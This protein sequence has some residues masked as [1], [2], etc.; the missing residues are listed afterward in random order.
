MIH[1]AEILT[2]QN[3]FRNEW[4][5]FRI[6]GK[7]WVIKWNQYEKKKKSKNKIF[8]LSFF[9][10]FFLVRS[11]SLSPSLSP[12]LCILSELMGNSV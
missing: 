5:M 6:E 12:S 10:S 2:N 11:L 9:L 1:R 4:G 3:D 7:K 8:F